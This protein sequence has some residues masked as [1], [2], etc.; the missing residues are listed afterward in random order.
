MNS[1]TLQNFHKHIFDDQ[2]LKDFF[3]YRDIGTSTQKTYRIRL[4]IYCQF[5]DQVYRKM[6]KEKLK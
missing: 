6:E 2:Y 1:T 4:G 3:I 5:T